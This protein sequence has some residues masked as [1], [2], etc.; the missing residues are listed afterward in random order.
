M[1]TILYTQHCETISKEKKRQ[2]EN[3]KQKKQPWAMTKMIKYEYLRLGM[4][5]GLC[6]LLSW[7]TLS[8]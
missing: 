4:S 3:E 2:N 8:W 5:C 6:H 7:N 1:L